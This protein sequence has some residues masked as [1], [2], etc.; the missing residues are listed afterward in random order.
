M[1]PIEHIRKRLANSIRDEGED[2]LD[3]LFSTYG[4]TFYARFSW[5]EGWEHASI[6]IPGQKRTPTW[7]EMCMFKDIFWHEEEL[8][9]QIHPPKS[10][11]V[12]NVDNCLHL[13]RPIEKEI[14]QPKKIFV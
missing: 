2:G 5:G 10:Q 12:N 9:I 8:V 14:P 13:W 11:Y 6:S 3:A 4:I 1:R 7:A